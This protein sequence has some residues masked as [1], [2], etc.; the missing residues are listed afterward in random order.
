MARFSRTALGAACVLLVAP[1]PHAR[2][3]QSH[4]I[5]SFDEREPATAC[6]RELLID[7]ETDDRGA[8]LVDGQGILTPPE[9]GKRL[10]I[11]GTGPNH[12]AAIFDSSSAGPNHDCADPDLLVDRGNVLILQSDAPSNPPAMLGVFPVPDDDKDGGLVTFAFRRPSSPIAIDLIDL[13]TPSGRKWK[14]ARDREAA[15]IT[16]TDYSGLARI[17]SVPVGWTGDASL[18]EP[19]SETLDLQSLADQPGFRSTATAF[20][21]PGFDPDLVVSMTVALRAEGALDDLR[22]LVPCVVLD[23]EVEDDGTPVSTGTPLSNGQA[24]S[25]PPVFGTELALFAAGPNAGAAIFDS[26]RAGPNDPGPDNELL[27]GLGHVLILQSDRRAAQTIAGFFDV[28]DNDPDGGELFFLFPRPVECRSLDLIDVNEDDD[29]GAS[30]LLLD[31]GGRTRTYTVPPGWTE[32]L[33]QDGPPGFRT[34]DLT[35][36]S[37]QPGFMDT[38]T[39]QSDPGFAPDEVIEIVVT[40]G[41]AQALDNLCF[42]P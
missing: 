34:L 16:L 19:G 31:T 1:S 21:D 33:L 25:T 5:Q 35:T 7:F 26:T 13:S 42:I 28:P 41:D 10:A 20:E 40:L 37:A 4:W 38:V 22:L 39:A 18:G 2:G 24:V 29:A 11:A 30:V 6:A 12:G 3:I 8:L 9:F 32:Q 15:R 23:F 17:Y 36:T 14:Y 27:V